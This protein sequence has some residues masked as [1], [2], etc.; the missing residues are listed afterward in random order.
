MRFS[1][2]N[3]QIPKP[4]KQTIVAMIRRYQPEGDIPEWMIKLITVAYQ[5]GRYDEA[6]SETMMESFR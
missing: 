1:E 5:N 6:S 2:P 3:D 4:T